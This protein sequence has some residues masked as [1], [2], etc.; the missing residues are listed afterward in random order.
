[1]GCV[2]GVLPGMLP[3][4]HGGVL[5]LPRRVGIMVVAQRGVA[6]PGK[7]TNTA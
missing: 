7:V 4:N 3:K 5:T 6:V 1:M 2:E